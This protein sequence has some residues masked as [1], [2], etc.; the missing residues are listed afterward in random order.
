MH[1]TVKD[2]LEDYLA[3]PHLESPRERDLLRRTM[4][5]TPSTQTT[6]ATSAARLNYRDR[7]LAGTYH[8]HFRLAEDFPDQ[9]PRALAAALGSAR[10]VPLNA[11]GGEPA[12]A[13]R[14]TTQPSALAIAQEIDWL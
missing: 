3:Q 11:D 8:A 6:T 1:G 9:L 10:R 12:S 13:Q 2:W 5:A 7:V 14:D 4:T